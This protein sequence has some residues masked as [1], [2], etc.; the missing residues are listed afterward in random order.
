MY[1]TFDY[2]NYLW[3]LLIVFAFL[4]THLLTLQRTRSAAIKF[5]NFEAIQRVSKGS[6]AR[7]YIGKLRNR[8]IIL[9]LF[10]TIILVSLIF[11]F[12]RTTVWYSAE[13]A[14]F[15]YILAIDTSTSMLS[16][17]IAPNRLEASK[18]AAK[19]FINTVPEKTSI[20]VITFHSNAFIMS[21]ISSDKEE[22]ITGIE[23]IQQKVTGS[24]DIGEAITTGTN[25]LI[26]QDEQRSIVLISDGADTTLTKLRE[27]LTYAIENEIVIHTVKVGTDEGGFID[28]LNITLPGSADDTTL[29]EIADT[30]GGVFFESPT[31]EELEQAFLDIAG[32]KETNIPLNL[33]FPL[34]LLSLL[35]LFIKWTWL[36]NKYRT[37]P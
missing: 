23:T 28:L 3:L 29:Q 31:K 35:L 19:L 12:A 2:P 16:D 4:L 1:V 26:N 24:T 8:D 9:L 34:L 27:D 32:T 22:P 20:G 5:A 36:Y 30:T 37:I 21:Q 11:A 15:S 7:P 13:G 10:K 33:T 18:E 6:M 17:D 14:E 25:M